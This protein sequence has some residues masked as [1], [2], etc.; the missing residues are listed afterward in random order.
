[1]RRRAA[2]A[3]AVLQLVLTVGIGGVLIA[4][5][6]AQATTPAPAARIMPM[7]PATEAERRQWEID[8]LS[9]LLHAQQRGAPAPE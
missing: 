4:V 7:R 8:Q 2:L 1:M 6:V 9:D 5:G 3:A